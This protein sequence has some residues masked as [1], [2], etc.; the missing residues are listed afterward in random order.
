MI[1][2]A[3]AEMPHYDVERYC[4][5]IASLGGSMSQMM[6]QSC[7]TQEQT[8]YNAL[9]PRW[10]SLPE[11]MRTYCDQIAAVGGGGSYMMLESCV[12]QEESAASSNT[13]FHFKR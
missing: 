2:A 3:H 4:T 8:A 12:K 9:K 13:G 6:L 7:Y 11:A 5:E 1:S 10:D